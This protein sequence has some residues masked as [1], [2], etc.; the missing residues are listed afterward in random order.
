MLAKQ[1]SSCLWCY[2][3]IVKVVQSKDLTPLFVGLPAE[4][5]LLGAQACSAGVPSDCIVI[6]DQAQNSIE[7]AL[8]CLP[9]LQSAKVQHTVLVTSDYHMPRCRLLFE[10]VLQGTG[11]ALSWAEVFI[12]DISRCHHYNLVDTYL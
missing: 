8:N 5:N 9:L 6:E 3:V 7:N 4:A 12:L 2:L 10:M 1:V 11:I